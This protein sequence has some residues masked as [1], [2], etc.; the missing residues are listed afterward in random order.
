MADKQIMTR[1]KRIG[2]TWRSIRFILHYRASQGKN[3]LFSPFHIGKPHSAT[4]VQTVS[5]ADKERS[6]R[7]AQLFIVSVPKSR[8]L[9]LPQ[10]LSLLVVNLRTKLSGNVI[11]SLCIERVSY[12]KKAV[13]QDKQELK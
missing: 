10:Y 3:S 4:N 6:I 9:K 2:R 5:K 1:I 8:D 11:H 13:K 12:P 7:G